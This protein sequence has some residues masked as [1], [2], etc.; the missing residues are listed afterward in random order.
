M[1]H[2][3]FTDTGGVYFSFVLHGGFYSGFSLVLGHWLPDLEYFATESKIETFQVFVEWVHY[4][5][6]HFFR[7]NWRSLYF[8]EGKV[9]LNAAFA[10]FH[11]LGWM[12]FLILA[13]KFSFDRKDLI[14]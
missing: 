2:F 13:Q 6:P 4:I 7:L 12:V 1:H 8:L 10:L 9:E 3:V 11:S 5:I 14:E